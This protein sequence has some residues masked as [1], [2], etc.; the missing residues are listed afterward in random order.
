MVYIFVTK[1]CCRVDFDANH[2]HAVKIKATMMMMN[3]Y[4]RVCSSLDFDNWNKNT[5]RVYGILYNFINK[6]FGKNPQISATPLPPAPLPSPPCCPTKQMAA[7]TS[8]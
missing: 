5:V 8:P 6:L 7:F 2:F 1:T 3:N 4:W